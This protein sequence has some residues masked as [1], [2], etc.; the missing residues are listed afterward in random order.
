MM[1]GVVLLRAAQLQS[2]SGWLQHP[3]MAVARGGFSRAA[4]QQEQHASRTSS[5]LGIAATEKQ[6]SFLRRHVSSA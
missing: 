5:V 4:Q 2:A 6:T 1:I 3:S